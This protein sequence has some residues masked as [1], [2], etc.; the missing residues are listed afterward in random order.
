MEYAL[1]PNHR[2][3]RSLRVPFSLPF[4]APAAWPLD[5]LAAAAEPAE[6]SSEGRRHRSGHATRRMFQ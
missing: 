5:P 2:N 1:A 3:L 6:K 4:E